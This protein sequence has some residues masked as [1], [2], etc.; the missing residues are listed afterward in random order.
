M[1]GSGD[2]LTNG[3][4]SLRVGDPGIHK[5]CCGPNIWVAASGSGTV[6]INGRPAHR[7]TDMT[8]HCGGVGKLDTGSGDVITGG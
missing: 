5:A 4:R 1:D 7:K 8:A 6:L 2:V 3:R